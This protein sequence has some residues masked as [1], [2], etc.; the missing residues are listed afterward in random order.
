MQGKKQDLQNK[1][2]ESD[3]HPPPF[4]LKTKPMLIVVKCRH[5]TIL[6]F[7]KRKHND[8]LKVWVRDVLYEIADLTTTKALTNESDIWQAYHINKQGLIWS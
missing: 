5:L 7:K 3:L 8:L 4:F 2:E 1:K 6:D